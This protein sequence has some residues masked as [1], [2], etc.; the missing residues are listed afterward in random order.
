METYQSVLSHLAEPQK[1]NERDSAT[2]T[3]L[4]DVQALWFQEPLREFAHY[5]DGSE[6][7]RSIAEGYVEWI[8]NVVRERGE[9]SVNLY[10]HTDAAIETLLD[11][12]IEYAEK[13]DERKYGRPIGKEVEDCV[14]EL[15]VQV[16]GDTEVSLNE[17]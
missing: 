3:T 5:G 6:T 4:S 14:G 11:A 10:A 8:D 2:H 1:P 9:K 13:T 16:A 15:W 12:L 17:S 7:Q